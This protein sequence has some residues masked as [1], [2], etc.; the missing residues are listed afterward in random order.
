MVS[1]FGMIFLKSNMDRFIDYKHIQ[2]LSRNFL[3]KS[4]MDRFIVWAES[5]DAI[6]E[7]SF[8]IQYG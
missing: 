2:P 6:N 8:K 5:R 3:L 1:C 4:N 7:I